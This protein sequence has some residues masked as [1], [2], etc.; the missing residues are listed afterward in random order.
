MWKYLYFFLFPGF[1]VAQDNVPIITTYDRVTYH[2]SSKNWSVDIDSKGYVYVG[3]HSGLLVA[4]GDEWTLKELPEKGLLRSV[5]V[6]ANRV[7]SGGYEEFGFWERHSNGALEYFSI[8]NTLENFEFHNEEIWKILT[9]ED[10]VYFQSFSTVFVY[11]VKEKKVD[12]IRADGGVLFLLEAG[13]QLVAQSLSGGLVKLNDTGFEPIKDTEKLT[14]EEVKVVLPIDQENYIL[15]SGKS[16]LYKW[17]SQGITTWEC[18]AN[19]VLRQKQIN[20]GVK[21]GHLFVLGTITDGV[22]FVD[23]SGKIVRHLNADNALKNN[24]ILSM[25]TDNQGNVWVTHDQ[26]LSFIQFQFP[27]VPIT[28]T[29][30]PIGAVHAAAL[31]ESHLFIGSNQGLYR[32]R[33]PE[34]SISYALDDFQIIP[35]TQG[36]V[37][38]LKVFDDELLI[39]HTNG[40]FSFED[41]ILRK[42][43]HVSG[44]TAFDY[45]E[46]G[47]LIEGT[48]A[49]II[50]LEKDE[51]TD[52]VESSWLKGFT[53]P[54]KFI[55]VDF[56]GNI[57]A[58]HRRKGIFKLKIEGDSIKQQMYLGEKTGFEF[59]AHSHVF[60]IQNRVVFT[61][62]NGLWTYDDLTDQIVRYDKFQEELGVYSNARR[63]VE[64]PDDYY[65]FIDS[66]RAALF[67]I[68]DERMHQKLVLNLGHASYGMVDTY[69][70]IVPLEKDLHLVCLEEGFLLI[71]PS[72]DFSNNNTGEIYINNI[73]DHLG[74]KYNLEGIE[75][76]IPYSGRENSIRIDFSVPMFPYDG[77][78]YSTF[79]E[80][81]DYDWG[82]Y[83]EKS[84][85][86]FNR[87]PWGEYKL[88]VRGVDS[89]GRPFE[90][91]TLIFLINPP[92]YVTSWALFLYVASLVLILVLIRK[93]YITK[94]ERYFQKQQEKLEKERQELEEKRQNELVKLQNQNLELKLENKSK[95]LA[96]HTFH[97]KQRNETLIEV[98]NGLEVLKKN[99]LHINQRKSF[100]R[101]IDLVNRN[102][103]KGVEWEAFEVNFDQANNNFFKRMKEQFPD[104][105]QSDLRICAYLHLNLTSKEIAPLLNISLRA[106]ENHRYR[107]R[108]KL[109]LTGTDNLVEFLIQF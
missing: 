47:K 102:L 99:E 88:H 94:R 24:T 85:V 59:D 2:A 12:V 6:D 90:D 83:S 86:V 38:D 17:T 63:I 84:E 49:D 53:E 72:Q 35:G 109:G 96:N 55:Q 39:G 66:N 1:V 58:S 46:D 45:L 87:L 7:Y 97:V 60:S 31:F 51:Q 43:S 10:K 4:D 104:L 40:T 48:Y 5:K 107:L 41:D 27:F 22:Y 34:D 95:E 9:K 76:E 20:H 18:E 71:D 13:D 30:N 37:W 98:R 52:W 26:G 93:S 33:I 50:I 28:S 77:I 78:S 91:K 67:R 32:A 79:L 36:Q 89:Y 74:E 56:Q 68:E 62:A 8:S 54:L 70:N 69:E 108:K 11:D 25:C 92:W 23:E 73:E 103:N 29:S 65:W 42:V 80:G 81:Y 75:I 100:D 101:I 15:G 16:G 105:T 14:G 82:D 64:S 61:S 44:G 3:N 19:D 21:V 106:V 57:W